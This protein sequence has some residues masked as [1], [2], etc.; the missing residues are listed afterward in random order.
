M[1]WL[2]VFGPPGVGKSTVCDHFWHPHA[3]PWQT[4]QTF[5]EEWGD[6]LTEC[7]LLLKKVEGHFSYQNCLGMVNRSLRKMAAVDAKNDDRTYIQTGFAQRGLGFGWRLDN[8]EEIRRYYEL[9]PT[10]LGVGPR[11]ARRKQGFHGAPYGAPARDC[12]G[13]F[14]ETRHSV[15]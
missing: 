7:T 14:E 12:A 11:G 2:D 4:V 9:M 15:A 10:S 5:P 8:P 13:S 1:M 6:F 3:I